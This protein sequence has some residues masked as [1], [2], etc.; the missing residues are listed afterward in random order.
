MTEDQQVIT[1]VVACSIVSFLFGFFA[2]E[3]HGYWSGAKYVM[4]KVDKL[5]A[6]L[7]AKD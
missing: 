7:S 2:G 5:R 6:G 3:I 1:L 4:N